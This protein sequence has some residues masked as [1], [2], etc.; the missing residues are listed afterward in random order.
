[1]ACGRLTFDH[2][3]DRLDI[4][5]EDGSSLGGLHCGE[6]LDVL[7]DHK[8]VPTRVEYDKD[9]YLF[10]LYRSGNIPARLNVCVC[11]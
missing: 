4:L 9:W 3:N 10:G 11:R 6:Q 5:F 7:I 8:W 2:E 1:M